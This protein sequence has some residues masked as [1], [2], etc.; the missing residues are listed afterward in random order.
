MSVYE[1]ERGGMRERKRRRELGKRERERGGGRYWKKRGES[2]KEFFWLLF[3]ISLFSVFP[4]Q[5]SSRTMG[6]L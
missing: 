6:S 5:H 3:D 4:L 2:E 1:I